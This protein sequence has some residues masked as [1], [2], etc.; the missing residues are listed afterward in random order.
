MFLLF[1][2]SFSNVIKSEQFIY[3]IIHCFMLEQNTLK[4]IFIV[5]VIKSY[6]VNFLSNLS[7]QRTVE[8][9]TWVRQK[10]REEGEEDD[11]NTE[12]V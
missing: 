12:K 5:F 8:Q 2:F 9:L 4:L 7:L 10:E 11:E 1:N 3:L 6:K